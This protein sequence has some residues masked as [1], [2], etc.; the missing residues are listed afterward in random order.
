MGDEMGQSI[1]ITARRLTCAAM[2]AA[3]VLAQGV[4]TPTVR[5]DATSPFLA[6]V[7][8]AAQRLQTATDV[9]AAK[10]TTGGPIED[11]AR[12]R[13]V[14]D[15]VVAAA[16]E[17]AVD[18]DFVARAFRDQIDATVAVEYGLFSAWK[19]DHAAAPTAAPNLSASRAEIDR[20]NRTIVDQFAAQW[21]V[22]QSPDCAATL[23]AART[24]VVAHRQ[25]DSLYQRGLDHAT[26]SY[27]R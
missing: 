22:L 10:W 7:D 14:I 8:A 2:G 5:A 4:A 1:E 27:C 15:D 17:R 12:E 11:P 25:L 23:S 20:L 18:P 9:A 24:V 3:V 26:H 13:Q 21:T 6:L 16:R 19:T